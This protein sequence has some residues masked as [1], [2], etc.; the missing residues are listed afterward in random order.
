[1]ADPGVVAVVGGFGNASAHAAAAV[2]AAAGVPFVVAAATDKA[3]A[4]EGTV[5]LPAD[6]EAVARLVLL[7]AGP[8][9]VR[10]WYVEGK[11][12]LAVAMRQ[13]L[14]DAAEM[15][16]VRVGDADVVFYA[17]D[18]PNEAATFVRSLRSAANQAIFVGGPALDTP[19]FAE[20]AGA[21]AV[22][23][24]YV[25][26]AGP[27]DA[28]FASAYRTV[29]GAAPTSA[30]ILGYQAT[31]ILL[32]AWNRPS[33]PTRT[34]LTE[35]LHSSEESP[36]GTQVQYVPS[37]ALYRLGTSGYP[38]VLVASERITNDQKTK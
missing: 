26:L 25:S 8:W 22:G 1:V 2:L 29:T 14:S 31:K 13:T 28:D 20:L 7:W 9:S 17:G 4:G 15:V 35:A 38:G 24:Y 12:S 32:A 34:G 27:A 37:V 36:G 5:R 21:E 6:D 16:V 10:H 3:L 23:S 18:D 11:G 19:H 33:P 30:A